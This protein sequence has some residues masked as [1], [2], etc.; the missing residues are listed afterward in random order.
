MFKR[1]LIDT[2][3][4]TDFIIEFSVEPIDEE[5]VYE[6]FTGCN[7]I[8]KSVLV[9]T[10]KHENK[11]SHIR[12]YKKEKS[13]EILPFE[14]MPPL[15]VENGIVLGRIATLGQLNQEVF[16]LKE[17]IWDTKTPF[18]SIRRLVQQR[19]EIYNIRPGLYG[20]VKMKTQNERIGIFVETSMNKND[21]EIIGFN[22]SYYQGILLQVGNLKKL[23]TFIP[24]QDKNKV[25]L[26][27]TLKD[28]RTLKVIPPFSYPNLIQRSSTIDVIW[29]NDREMPHSFFEIEH[30]T[31]IQNSLLKFNDLQDFFVRM[32]ITAD[33]ARKVEYEN[34]IKY[35]SFKE[36]HQRVKFLD[37]DT[38][39][40]QYENLIE[41]QNYNF[42]L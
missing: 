29:F 14:T 10:L 42:V 34:K 8:L 32:V 35:S 17:C 24:N 41:Q 22:H 20:L 7:G 39:A 11:D 2:E 40:K 31:D 21:K 5:L 36:I 9:R 33:K 26:N 25:F 6:Y 19:P 1:I 30:S 23:K 4:I 16:K 13:Y 12:D 18:A 38:L 28:I 37:Y 15:V 3:E 27:Q